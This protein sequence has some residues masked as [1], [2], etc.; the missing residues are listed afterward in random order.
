MEKF[1]PSKASA[2]QEHIK[3]LVG[4]VIINLKEINFRE[5][6]FS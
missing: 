2:Y 4:T 5:D 3:T 1:R 6:Q